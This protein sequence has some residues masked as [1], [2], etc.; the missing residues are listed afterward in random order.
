MTPETNF[1]AHKGLVLALDWHPSKTFTL[2]TGSRDRT[3]KIWN[4]LNTKSPV[5][6]IQTI[7]AVGRLQWR[8]NHPNQLASCASSVDSN[9]HVWNILRPCIPIAS[10]EGHDEIVSGIQ[11]LDTPRSASL[12]SSVSSAPSRMADQHRLHGKR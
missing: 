8:P 12:S 10:I 3:I 2:A 4:V 1:T 9:V 6:T 5:R 11:W 7:A